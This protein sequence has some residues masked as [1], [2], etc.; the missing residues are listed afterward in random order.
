[1][2][3]QSYLKNNSQHFLPG[4]KCKQLIRQGI[5]EH[6]NFPNL[7]KKPSSSSK[8]K[9]DKGKTRRRPRPYQAAG[10]SGLGDQSCA[11]PPLTSGSGRSEAITQRS[12]AGPGQRPL[13]QLP[14]TWQEQEVGR[15][16]NV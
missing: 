7:I 2:V 14:R 12:R 1:M 5:L 11:R 10:P 6:L 9:E 13:T 4:W 3:L 16:D 15:R 8:S